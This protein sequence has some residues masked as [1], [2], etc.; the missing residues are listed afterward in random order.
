MDGY[1]DGRT[2]PHNIY[3]AVPTV[4]YD[5]VPTVVRYLC[6]AGQISDVRGATLR[7][8]QS[9]T[10]VND[11][12]AWADKYARPAA[13]SA[14][15]GDYALPV[16]ADAFG[17]IENP[18]QAHHDYPAVDIAVPTGTP[19]Y[20]I[21]HA[22]VIAARPDD[23]N[24][25]GT[26]ILSGDDGATYIYCH[27]S[28][29]LARQGDRVVAGQL[30]GRSGG[31]PRTPGAGNTTGPH[32]HVAVSVNGTAVCPQPLILAIW[33]GHPQPPNSAPTGGCVQRLRTRNWLTA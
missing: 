8:N 18:L 13:T 21:T 4:I 20:A 15:T 2:D 26:V 1:G 23:G 3:D 31:Q 19:V 5:A 22:S 27:F 33:R 25:G 7:Y 28:Q 11:V 14:V 10:Y 29:V 16:P 17:P 32:L 30:L 6:P 9:E 12:L 24:C